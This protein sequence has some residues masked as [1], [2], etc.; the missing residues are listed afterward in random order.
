MDTQIVAVIE[1]DAN[2]PDT[3]SILTETGMRH[4]RL[5]VVRRNALGNV[6]LRCDCGETIRLSPDQVASGKY[7]E[8][9]S[10]SKWFRKSPVNRF[11]GDDIYDIGMSRGRNAKDRCTNPDNRLWKNYGG[12]GIG[13]GFE[14]VEEYATHV[15]IFALHYGFE[16]Q[17]DRIDNDKGYEPGNIRIISRKD[18]VRNRRVTRMINGVPL[19]EIAEQNGIHP[20]NDDAK[21]KMLTSRYKYRSGKRDLSHEDVLKMIEEVNAHV[22]NDNL[23]QKSKYRKLMVAGVRLSQ[24]LGKLG[25]PNNR[26]VYD[27]AK[28][29]FTGGKTP[30][31]QEV[32][33]HVLRFAE[34]MRIRPAAA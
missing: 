7:Y 33:E 6:V 17:V 5:T 25:F 1:N 27:A 31:E 26:A 18:N 10:C 20:I 11:F 4:G 15:G 13:F 29:K 24:Y 30:S 28:L 3:K 8:C 2:K 19:A 12:R 32:S 22:P 23:R 34:K 16:G 9:G 14:T 21:Y